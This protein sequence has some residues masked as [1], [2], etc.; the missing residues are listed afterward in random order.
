MVILGTCRNRLL[1][2]AKARRDSWRAVCLANMSNKRQPAELIAVI[3]TRRSRFA[4]LAGLLATKVCMTCHSQIWTNA[5]LL[6]PV[7]DSWRTNYADLTRS[8]QF[9]RVR[10]FR[11]LDPYQQR[12][13][14]RPVA[15]GK[16]DEMPLI[17][18]RTKACRWRE[19]CLRCH[20]DPE[21][22]A[23][24]STGRNIANLHRLTRPTIQ[25]IRG[26]R[27]NRW[28]VN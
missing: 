13:R 1:S 27:R 12:H 25:T 24:A 16:V 8:S 23:A 5:Q 6:Q 4:L 26:R 28:A 14:M 15:T 10:F 22:G 11:P 21:S 20:R 7:R 19:W 17:V 18:G 3:A 2:P 9:A